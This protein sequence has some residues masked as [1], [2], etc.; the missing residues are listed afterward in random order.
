[1]VYLNIGMQLG[2]V[3]VDDVVL[4]Q[5]HDKTR[6]HSIRNNNKQ[7]DVDNRLHINASKRTRNRNKRHDMI[8]SYGGICVACHADNY[9]VL[10]LDHVNNDGNQEQSGN[11]RLIAEYLKHGVLKSK[12][13]LLCKNCNWLKHLYYTELC[14]LEKEG[15]PPF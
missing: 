13:Q 10:E 11:T 4:K 8:K 6:I 3:N 5:I 14:I 15:I 7:Y 1:M 2:G 9:D 12:Y